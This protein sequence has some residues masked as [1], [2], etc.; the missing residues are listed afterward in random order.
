MRLKTQRR[1]I[2]AAMGLTVLALIG[3]FTVAN[4][5][6]GS[7][8]N[9]IQQGS[10]TTTIGAVVGI[11]WVSTSLVELVSAAST[12]SCITVGTACNV[13]STS[14]SNC[15]GGLAGSTTCAATDWVEQVTLST[16]VGTAINGVANLTL[17]VVSSGLPHTGTSYFYKDSAPAA[18]TYIVLDFDIGTATNGPAPVT[19]VTVVA[20]T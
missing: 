9:A 10:H 14:Y 13:T 5:S 1:A 3:G 7:A 4:L 11:S 12:A 17:V 19:S 6:L 20:N 8:P 15:T 18:A 2:Y 16:T